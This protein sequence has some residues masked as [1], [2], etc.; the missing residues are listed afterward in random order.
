MSPQDI[1][2]IALMVFSIL[3][4]IA[5]GL[6]VMNKINKDNYFKLFIVII[7]PLIITV[8]LTTYKYKKT[9]N[10]LFIS[11]KSNEQLVCIY[12]ENKIIVQQ[13]NGYRLVNDYLIKNEKVINFKKC[14]LLEYD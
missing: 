5:I 1:L 8:M 10:E 4:L 6:D 3:V 12:D 2:A 7:V 9:Y 14:N 11:F 13:D